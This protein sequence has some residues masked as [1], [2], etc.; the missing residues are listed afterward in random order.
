MPPLTFKLFETIIEMLGSPEHPVKMPDLSAVSLPLPE[1]YEKK[2]ALP[3]LEELGRVG[4][5]LFV[6]SEVHHFRHL[7]SAVCPKYSLRQKVGGQ[8]VS[9][10]TIKKK[11]IMRSR[12]KNEIT[13]TRF[14]CTLRFCTRFVG[15]HR[16]FPEQD[17]RRNDWLGGETRALELIVLR[18][19]IEK[20]VSVKPGSKTCHVMVTFLAKSWIILE[21]NGPFKCY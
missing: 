15:V 14:E 7:Y 19:N 9:C 3:T 6:I 5:G 8:G 12:A 20:E 4:R 1:H 2:F 18:K 11:K 13:I 17:T 10:L 21:Q 16:E